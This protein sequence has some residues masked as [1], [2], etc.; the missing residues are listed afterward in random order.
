MT[1]LDEPYEKLLDPEKSIIV[2]SDLHLGGNEDPETAARFS[3]FLDRILQLGHCSQ[4]TDK[5]RLCPPEKIILLGDILELWDPRD[6]NRDN[7]VLDA[8]IPFSKLEE[9]GCQI[10]YVTGNHDEEIGEITTCLEKRN[11]NV[12]S[13][14]NNTK[15]KIYKRSFIPG[16]GEGLDV[17]GVHYAFL[18]G[19]QFDPEQITNTISECLDTRFD[20]VN[21]IEDL[22]NSSAAKLIPR[23]VNWT[24]FLTWI[25]LL[26]INFFLPKYPFVMAVA[27]FSWAIVLILLVYGCYLF[28]VKFRDAISSDIILIACLIPSLALL[29]LLPLGFFVPGIYPGLFLGV[30][31]VYSY[32]I[33]VVSLPRIIAF[34]KRTF[35]NNI[36]A[37]DKTI[38]DI[39]AEDSIRVFYKRG[40][41]YFRPEKYTWKAEVVV[42]GHTHCAGFYPY[43]VPDKLLQFL[44]SGVPTKFLLF[45]TGCWIR[46]KEYIKPPI[47]LLSYLYDRIKEILI[48]ISIVQSTNVN[49]PLKSPC[50]DHLDTFVYIDKNGICLMEWKD[51]PANPYKG[52]VHKINCHPIGTIP[53]MTKTTPSKNA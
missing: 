17:G 44:Q 7:V 35:Y 28:A 30:L 20:P 53:R 22:A 49:A 12:I 14:L 36:K 48:K 5:V 34:G 38:K 46:K 10:I 2:I 21:F 29:L 19:Q 23:W 41:R 42:F 40:R 24:M 39:V 8:I 31:L 13:L 25:G 32:F 16:D 27:L 45:N 47:S 52:T 51:D 9:T 15:L 6:Q 33:S 3:R 4:D 50:L 1:A 26:I 18:H 11:Q 43:T 37:K